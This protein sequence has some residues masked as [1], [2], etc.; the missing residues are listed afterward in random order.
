MLA[1][2]FLAALFSIPPAFALDANDEQALAETQ[3]LLGDQKA[4]EAF[5]KENPDA[6]KALDQAALTTGGDKKK[7]S[8]MNAISADVF[9]DMV[10]SSNGDSAAMQEKLQQAL[11]DPNA[12]LQQLSPE[13]QKRI[14][15]LASE[16]EKQQPKK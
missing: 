13:Q 10:K 7:Q 4:L 12:F 6:K 3:R 5:A 11:K 16:L 1:K 15:E 14:R 8:E 9:K 2:I